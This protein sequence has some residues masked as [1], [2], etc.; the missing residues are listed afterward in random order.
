MLQSAPAHLELD[1]KSSPAP[2]QYNPPLLDPAARRE[3]KSKDHQKTGSQESIA[4]TSVQP[5]K[6]AVITATPVPPATLEQSDDNSEKP[7]VAVLA[8]DKATSDLHDDN[9]VL[10]DVRGKNGD[11]VLFGKLHLWLGGAG[12]VDGYA[13]DGLFT[14]G[15]DG[16]SASETYVRRAEGVLRASFFDNTEVKIQ[17]DFDANIYRNVYWRWLSKSSSQSVTV[18]NQKEP[19]GQDYLV[20]NKFTTAMETSAPSTAFG[21]FRSMGVRYNGWSTL[22][23]EDNP[24]PL[25]FWGDSRTYVT[26]SIGVF[27]QDVENSNDTDWAVTGRISAG[28]NKTE[29]QGFHLGA[30]ASYRHGEYD[31]IAPRPGIQDAN[32]IPLA[33]PAADTQA[34]IALEGSYVHGSL[35]SQIEF[36]ASDYSGGTLDSQGW[37]TYGQVG[38]LFNGKRRPYEPRWGQ[39]APIN[40]SNGHVFEVFSRLSITHGNDDVNSSN[41]L[42]L[43]TLGGNWYYQRFRVSANLI[44]ADSDRNVYAQNDGHALAMRLQYLF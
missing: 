9:T 22:E 2:E 5:E 10:R 6:E 11:L 18:G 15:E 7:K 39:W 33:Q 26:S 16:D 38:W 21:S 19:I 24:L 35:H 20:G 25:R 23:S 1:P 27:G 36:Y 30:S 3:D 31:R 14:L 37:G 28:G 8:D 13:G 44:L 40:A 17:Y 4:G 29:T 12:Q 42:A 41:T 32:R 43:L 34:L